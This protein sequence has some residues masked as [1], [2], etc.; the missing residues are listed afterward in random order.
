MVIKLGAGACALVLTALLLGGCSFG[1]GGDTPPSV[2]RPGSIPTA[3]PPA[4]LPEPIL[5]GESQGT[6]PRPTGASSGGSSTY[7]VKS[8]DTLFGIAASLGVPSDQQASW[9]AEVLR[10]N[11]LAEPSLLRA[12]QELRL[13]NLPTATPRASGTPAATGTPART[14]TPAS[15]TAVSTT[16]TPR[17]TVTGGGGAYT[18]VSGDYPFLIAQKLGVPAAQQA[19]WVDQLIAL[20]GIDPSRLFVGQVLQL[21]A[22]TPPISGTSSPTA[23]PVP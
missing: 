13:P 19:A 2:S 12:G 23:T 7:A 21:P 17:P 15:T 9:T 11:G 8:G 10:L 4:T 1:G 3:T 20:N 6:N 5:L 22:G 18:V 14:P 16:A